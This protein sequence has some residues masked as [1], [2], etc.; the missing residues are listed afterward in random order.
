MK[1]KTILCALFALSATLSLNA[2]E[3]QNFTRRQPVVSPEVTDS[4]VIFRLSAPYATE[5]SV[6]PSWL[7]YGPEAQQMG[8]M[9]RGDGGVWSVALPRPESEL[10]TYTFTVDGVSTLD[11]RGEPQDSR[12]L[13][14]S[15]IR[16]KPTTSA[17]LRAQCA[18][19]RCLRTC[20]LT[21]R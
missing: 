12:L 11:L 10:Y 17:S 15:S 21:L 14:S 8:K 5:V 16:S 1:A 7:G 6:S 19:N 18:R 2:Q 3:L 13:L 20:S 4:T 9:T